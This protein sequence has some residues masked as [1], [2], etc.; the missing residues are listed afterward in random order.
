M[1]TKRRPLNLLDFPPFYLQVLSF[2][3]DERRRYV[4]P[5]PSIPHVFIRVLCGRRGTP[6]PP[7]PLLPLFVTFVTKDERTNSSVVGNSIWFPVRPEV[8]YPFTTLID[9]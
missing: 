5:S 1:C 7:I 4:P 2:I 9:E 6:D 8:N 3:L